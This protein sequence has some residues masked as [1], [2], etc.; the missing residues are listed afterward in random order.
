MNEFARLTL[1][2]HQFEVILRLLEKGADVDEV[3]K[4]GWQYISGQ[5]PVIDVKVISPKDKIYLA[6]KSGINKPSEIRSITKVKRHDYYDSIAELIF[7]KKIISV[8]ETHLRTYQI[9]I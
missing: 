5:N 4:L 7:E 8:G 2:K 9:N 3:I 1:L 6:I